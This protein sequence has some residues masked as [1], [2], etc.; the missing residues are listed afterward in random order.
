MP[1]TFV[2][3]VATTTAASAWSR[4]QAK[5]PYFLF[6]VLWIDL[7]RQLSYTWE[8]RDQYSY[9]WFVPCFSLYLFW[10]RWLDRPVAMDGV[11][12][13]WLTILIALVLIA[14]LP[15]R[16]IFEINADWPLITWLYTASVVGLTLY[17][18][19]LAGGGPW[20][21]HFSFPIAFILVAVAW[22]YRIE[23]GL[24]QNLMQMAASLT[25]EILGFLDIPALQRGN[26]IEVSTG[27]VGVDE[28]CSG[29]R[30]FQS[31]LMA[32]LLM[33]ELYRLR[34]RSRLM[35]VGCGLLLAFGFNLIRTLFLS[36][37][38]SKHGVAIINKWHDSAG[39][40]IL[41]AC[42]LTLWLLAVWIRSRS[43]GVSN[44]P[45]P[46]PTHHPMSLTFRRYLLWIGCAALAALVATEA[47]YRAHESRMTEAFHWS[48]NFPTNQPGYQEI[49]LTPRVMGLMGHDTGGAASWT[50]D[51]GAA[52][53]AY[54]LR[55]NPRSMSAVMMS[56]VHRPDVCLPAAGMRQVGSSSVVRIDAGHLELP[57]RTYTY[58]A[59]SRT[60]YVFFCQW[61]DGSERQQGLEASK[62][63]GRL[64]S[65]LTG[66][67]RVGQQTLEFI[68][69][70]Y[71][72]IQEAETA[73]R[74][75]LRAL[76]RLEEPQLIH[77]KGHRGSQKLENESHAFL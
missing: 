40:T 70:G 2:E 57:F 14:L 23:K 11:S 77:L 55:W 75:Q 68:L 66:R 71:S 48:F 36:W 58:E 10:R 9:G 5:V 21:R 42:F 60:V 30:S 41:V 46:V 26:L 63:A 59:G 6:S 45:N 67:R 28:A 3:P 73:L 16:V 18:V 22:P 44:I 69:S 53:T 54:F 56:R 65:V 32:S 37:Q 12:S 7:V 19:F 13:R 15:L 43:T 38:A 35:M 74:R 17:G 39:L 1:G 8:T 51:A 20:V 52:W 72:S 25:V 33:G 29:I 64:Q 62:Q 50:G 27:V 76:I 47:W 49:E 24:T 61:E 4:W 34:A 31:T